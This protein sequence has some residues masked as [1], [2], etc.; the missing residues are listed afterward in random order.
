MKM[1]QFE[2]AKLVVLMFLQFDKFS[3]GMEI[4]VLPEGGFIGTENRIIM[5]TNLSLKS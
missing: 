1:L 3:V 2:Q 4:T 5:W